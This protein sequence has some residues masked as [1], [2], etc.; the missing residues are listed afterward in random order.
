MY[1][2]TLRGTLT[3]SKGRVELEAFVCSERDLLVVRTTPS[4]GERVRWDFTPSEARSTRFDFRTDDL[5]AGLQKN[6]A[7]VVSD[8]EVYQKL[9]VGG[10]TTTAWRVDDDTIYLTVAHTF[11]DDNSRSIARR[12]LRRVGSFRELRREHRGWWNRYYAKSFVSVPDGRI[13]SF[14]WIQLYKI[15]AATRADNRRSA[16]PRSGWSPPRGGPPGGTSTC[17]WSTG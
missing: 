16:P 1:D 12:T 2:A 11:P 14:Y 4:R 6:P 9:T 13:Q 17:S 8:N 15:A 3:T 10:G 5:P 7:P